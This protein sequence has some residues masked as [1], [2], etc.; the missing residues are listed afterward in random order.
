MVNVFTG[1]LMQRCHHRCGTWSRV[2]TCFFQ[3]IR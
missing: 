2:S 3:P 1:N